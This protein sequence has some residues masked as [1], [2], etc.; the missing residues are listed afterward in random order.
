LWK[1][2]RQQLLQGGTICCSAGLQMDYKKHS[3][4]QINILYLYTTLCI[5]IFV[6]KEIL[7]FY[8]LFNMHSTANNFKSAA[9]MFQVFPFI[10]CRHDNKSHLSFL[11]NRTKFYWS[12]SNL[13]DYQT[14]N[15]LNMFYIPSIFKGNQL[16]H[17]WE[18]W[19]L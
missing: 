8:L 9:P 4:A 16:K 2:C 11:E 3:R 12:S 14:V 18:F 5:Q 13:Q 17:A 6:S 19:F 1:E 10:N 7:Q 15:V